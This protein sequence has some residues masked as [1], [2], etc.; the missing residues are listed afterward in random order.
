MLQWLLVAVIVMSTVFGDLLQ[1]SEMKRVGEVHDFRPGKLG[2]LLAQ[3]A[4]RKYLILAV[5]FM[6]ISFFAFMKLLSVADLSFA[7]PASAATVVLETI[8]ARLLLGERVDIRRWA[9][10]GLVACGVALLAL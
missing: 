8:L 6:A 7:V 2:R 3:M 1:T 5:F 4:Q 10:A 9:G